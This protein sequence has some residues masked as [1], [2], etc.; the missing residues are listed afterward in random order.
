MLIG[1]ESLMMTVVSPLSDVVGCDVAT[2]RHGRADAAPHS[3]RR[4]RRDQAGPDSMTDRASL[5][6]SPFAF[7]SMFTAVG[8]LIP[9]CVKYLMRP[10]QFYI[11]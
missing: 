8:N 9:L 1:D 2:Y 11:F 4:R 5:I 10:S 3:H 7:I 6:F